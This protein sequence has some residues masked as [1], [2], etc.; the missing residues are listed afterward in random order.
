MR[1]FYE[2]W[3]K[4][5]EPNRQLPSND[6]QRMENFM[7]DKIPLLHFNNSHITPFY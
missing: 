1:I 6:L 5:F 7:I 3:V 4:I 2:E